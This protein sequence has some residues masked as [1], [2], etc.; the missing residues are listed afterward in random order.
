VPLLRGLVWSLLAA[1]A[2]ASPA[3]AQSDDGVDHAFD[4]Q[5][6][7][8]SQWNMSGSLMAPTLTGFDP[9]DPRVGIALLVAYAPSPLLIV[10]RVSDQLRSRPFDI[11][12][13]IVATAGTVAA[14]W[15]FVDSFDRPVDVG[16]GIQ[17]LA[18]AHALSWNLELLVTAATH[19]ALGDAADRFEPL[20]PMFLPFTLDGGGGVV[21]QWQN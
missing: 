3:L 2:S 21:A 17:S 15:G 4:I 1:I 12:Q 18:T 9:G 5:R 8:T 11:V 7:R 20:Q 13:L 14:T 16:L 6:P 19:L 10:E